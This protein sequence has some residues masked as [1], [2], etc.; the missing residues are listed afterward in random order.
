MTIVLFIHRD[1]SKKGVSLKNSIDQN[2]LKTELQ[3][4]A[5]YKSLKTRLK[6]SSDFNEQEIFILLVDSKI[7]L[8]KLTLMTDL[9]EDK[10]IIL[11]LP[12]E[13]KE[14]LSTASQFFP[15]F[16]TPMGN[17]YDDL[18]SVLNKILNQNNLNTNN[19]ITRGERK[20]V[21]SS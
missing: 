14:T 9:M 4:L 17:K 15:R 1:S 21:T 20:N 8:N 6:K 5:T 19:W 18:C 2:F 13:S 3:V 7:R 16:F 12:D 11:I 10:R